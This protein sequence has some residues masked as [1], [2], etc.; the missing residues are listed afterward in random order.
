MLLS[1]DHKLEKENANTFVEQKDPLEKL[2]PNYNANNQQ[3]YQNRINPNMNANINP[4]NYGNQQ[5]YGYNN[6]S[7]NQI[8]PQMNNNFYNNIG[9]HNLSV[10]GPKGQKFDSM[11]NRAVQNFRTKDGLNYNQF[12]QQRKNRIIQESL[13]KNLK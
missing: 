6:R 3:G 2:E 13:N 4:N 9:K 10:D 5:P 7:Q 12:I 8:Q 11:R 1:K